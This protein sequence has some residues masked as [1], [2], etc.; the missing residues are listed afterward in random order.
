MSINYWTPEED[1]LLKEL[2]QT[3][4]SVEEIAKRLGRSKGSI[5]TQAYKIGLKRRKRYHGC[6]EDCF[7]CQY[8]DCLKQYG[9][10]ESY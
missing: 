10:K 1:K 2:Y 9:F 7:H 3:K 6:D 8:H 5:S 4:M